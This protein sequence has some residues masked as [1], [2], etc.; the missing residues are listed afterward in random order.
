MFADGSVNNKS[1]HFSF[2]QKGDDPLN[3]RIPANQLSAMIKNLEHIREV[4][5]HEGINTGRGNLL[6]PA[7]PYQFFV[8]DE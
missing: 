1:V 6:V 2:Q 4:M 7:A 8:E 5:E 3:C